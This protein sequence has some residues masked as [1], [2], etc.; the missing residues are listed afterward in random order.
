MADGG[1]AVRGGGVHSDELEECHGK[2]HVLAT[3]NSA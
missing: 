1:V 3:F 2:D